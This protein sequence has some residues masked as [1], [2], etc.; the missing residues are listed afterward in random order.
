MRY[1]MNGQGG[2]QSYNGTYSLLGASHIVCYCLRE[3][4]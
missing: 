1:F 4:H 3:E 2:G